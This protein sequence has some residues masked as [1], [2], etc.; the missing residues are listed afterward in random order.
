MRRRH[1]PPVPVD[2]YVVTTDRIVTVPNALSMLRLVLVGVYCWL[3]L[4]PRADLAAVVVLALTGITD[5]LDGYI[6]RRWAQVSSI[7][8]ILDPL[9]DRITIA[10]VVVTLALREIIPWWLVAALV[11]REL[12][13]LALVPSL[14]RRGLSALPVHYLGKAATF[15]L[16]VG[17]P[18]L[19][20]GAGAAGWQSVIDWFGWALVL[21]GLGLYWYGAILYVE[22]TL[23]IIRAAPLPRRA[24]DR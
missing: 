17:F 15:V 12:V 23:R 19:L 3:V 4:G 2:A 10:A 13:L 8:Q 22:Q 7:G 21:W 14:R 18:M 1:D 20:A 6:A 5:Y 9:V 24:T 11:A 16:F